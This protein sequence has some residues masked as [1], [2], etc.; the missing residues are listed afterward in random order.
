MSVPPCQNMKEESGNVRIDCHV[1]LE[2]A[3]L[4]YFPKV[5]PEAIP[6]NEAIQY[7]MH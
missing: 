5:F 6:F 7:G 2:N 4:N 3:L 1:Q